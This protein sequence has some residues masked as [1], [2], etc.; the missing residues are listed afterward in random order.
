MYLSQF[1]IIIIYVFV[2]LYIIY[3]LN[4][5]E[6]QF[7]SNNMLECGININ[8]S[9]VDCPYNCG[10]KLTDTDLDNNIFMYCLNN[11]ND[12]LPKKDL[13]KYFYDN[14]IDGGI[15]CP[16]GSQKKL[17]SLEGQNSVYSICN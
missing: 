7:K 17:I 16:N 5:K 12:N 2:Y 8:S 15:N 13:N 1:V 14:K 10:L 9:N 6:E 11:K 4:I 3:L